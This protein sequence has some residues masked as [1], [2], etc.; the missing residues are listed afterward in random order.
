LRRRTY[1]QSAHEILDAIGAE[2]EVGICVGELGEGE[3]GLLL[4][5]GAADEVWLAEDAWGACGVVKL[6]ALLRALCLLLLDAGST[7][8]VSDVCAA[9]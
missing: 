1:D 5:D 8:S 6:D 7:L 4:A 3:G 9:I 2:V